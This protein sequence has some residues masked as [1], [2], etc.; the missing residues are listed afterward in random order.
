MPTEPHRGVLDPEYSVVDAQ[1]LIELASPLIRETLNHGSLVVVRCERAP[2]EPHAK[3]VGIAPIVL[4]RSVLEMIDGVE[5]LLRQSCVLATLPLLR[6]AFEA[7]L[8]LSFLAAR[9][10]PR[11]NLAWLTTYTH[12]RLRAYQ[13]LLPGGGTLDA[14]EKQFGSTLV[15][16]GDVPKAIAN[17]EQFLQLDHIRPIHEEILRRRAARRP[18]PWYAVF[19]GPQ[20][21]RQLAERVG[22]PAEYSMLYGYWSRIAHG[23]EMASFVVAEPGQPMAWRS[24]RHPEAFVEAATLAVGTM[25]GATRS[26]LHYARPGEPIRDWYLR[27]IRNPFRQLRGLE[28]NVRNHA[29]SV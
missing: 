22:R 26:L 17:L 23:N 16:P 25:L 8:G 21:L 28:V 6:S 27:E 1:P 14:W 7:G 18:T 9:K 12:Q 4:Y 3:D 5:V 11:L 29:S 20:D 19:N 13:N 24:V 2:D 15:A 10:D